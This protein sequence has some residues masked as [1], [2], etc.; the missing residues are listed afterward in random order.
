MRRA[1]DVET[2]TTVRRR[3]ADWVM[4]T[5][6]STYPLVARSHPGVRRW[7]VQWLSTSIVVRDLAPVRRALT[8]RELDV[9]CGRDQTAGHVGLDVEPGSGV[10]VVVA[11]CSAV[12]TVG[13]LLGRLDRT[14]AFY[15]N[16]VATGC[17]AR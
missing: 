8:G 7:H 4:T 1:E 5:Y 9:D 3:V 17:Q 15:G 13:A 16:V 12:N 2:G 6:M 14:A 11:F 10:D